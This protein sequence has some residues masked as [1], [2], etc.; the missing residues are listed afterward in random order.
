MEALE[1]TLVTIGAAVLLGAAV[2]IICIVTSKKKLKYSTFVKLIPSSFNILSFQTSDQ[3][4]YIKTLVLV[5]V[6][7]ILFKEAEK[8]SA[9][10]IDAD[11]HRLRH[12]QYSAL[13]QFR[14]TYFRRESIIWKQRRRNLFRYVGR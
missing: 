13:W 11:A 8:I 7:I 2:A 4:T 5:L 12:E 1:V 6:V 10:F 14:F 3:V 9:H